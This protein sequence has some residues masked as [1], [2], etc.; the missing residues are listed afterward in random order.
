MEVFGHFVFLRFSGF[1]RAFP[2]VYRLFL[3][4]LFTIHFRHFVLPPIDNQVLGA[5][6]CIFNDKTLPAFHL[7]CTKTVISHK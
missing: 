5:L 3:A 1:F 2:F 7:L 6:F 4:F